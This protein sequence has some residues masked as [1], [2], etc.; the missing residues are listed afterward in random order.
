MISKR[1]KIMDDVAR[2]AGGAAGLIGDT[3]KH[4]KETVK[5]RI[6]DIAQ[7]ID[8]VPRED[9]ERLEAMFLQCRDEQEKLKK[10][11]ADL[12]GALASQSE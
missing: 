9:F 3:S 1:E 2:V 6:D 5:T 4:I 12:E 11:V 7:D 10:R 8:L